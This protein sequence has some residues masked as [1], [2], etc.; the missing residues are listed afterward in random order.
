MYGM[1]TVN[2]VIAFSKKYCTKVTTYISRCAC[3]CCGH[4]LLFV[5][6]EADTNT[7]F[8]CPA[9]S[10][11]Y[12]E[13]LSDGTYRVWCNS[14]GLTQLPTFS[15][16]SSAADVSWISLSSNSLRAITAGAFTMFTN[17]KTLYI[18]GNKVGCVVIGRIVECIYV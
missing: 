14:K 8:V 16:S 12:C 18:Y 2:E 7:S 9:P 5:C 6:R 10:P 4:V 3:L 17:L 15:S 13:Q 1:P 11:C